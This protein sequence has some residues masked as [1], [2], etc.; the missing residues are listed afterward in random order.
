MK[1]TAKIGC[2]LAIMTMIIVGCSTEKNTWINRNYHSLTAHYN[3]YYNA[4]ELIDQGM[5]SYRDGRV[6]NYYEILPIDPVPDTAEVAALYPALDTAI[7]K[8]KKVIKNHSM[9]S[10]DRPARKKSEHNRWIDENWTTIGIASY[11]RRDYEGAMKSFKFVRKFYSND[12]SLY[13]GELWMAKT[14]IATGRLTEAK[15][16]L[17]NLDKAI[18]NEESAEE[19]GS[20]N[21]RS[22]IPG[23]K[24]KDDDDETAKVPKDIRFDLEKT[25]AQLALE[26]GDRVKA[27][28]YLEAS[29]EHA[30]FKDNVARVHFILGQLYSEEGDR[31]K[32]TEHFT[33][34]IK[35]RA[36]Y[37]MVFNARLKRAF[38]GTGEKVKKDLHKMMKDPKNSEFKD[39]I[40]YALAEIEFNE[41]NDQAAVDNLH[42]STFYS[43]SNTRQKGMSYERLGDY[44]FGRREYVQ[45]QK[46]YD[47]CA[48]VIK[49]TYPNA[50]G[51]RGKAQSLAKLVV[52]VET[53]NREDSLQ[54]IAMMDESSREK[55]VKDEIKRIKKAEEER[56][57]REAER[58]RE[59]QENQNL[60]VDVGNGS[61][62]YWNNPKVVREG[63]EEFRRLWG[64]RENE[65]NWRR[66]NKLDVNITLDSNDVVD[67]E[68]PV[69][70]EDTLTVEHLMSFVP[71]TD[72]MM[73]ASNTRLMKA[74]FDAGRIY[75]D[76]LKEPALA[77]KQFEKALDKG[78]M[79]DPHDLLSAYQLYHMTKERDAAKAEGYKQYILVNYPNSDFANYL[80]DPDYFIKK[81]E[82]D[83][84]AIQ[85]Y[86][87][88]LERYERALY[89]PVLTKANKVI[90]EEPDNIYRSKYM[91]L[92][93]MCLGKTESD[94]K[95]LLPVLEM[96]VEQYPGT[97]EA[98]RGQ[99][100]IDII[101]NGYSDNIVFEDNSG[102]FEFDERSKM[103]VIVFL[104]EGVSSQSGISRVS[105]FNNEYFNLEGL[106]LDTKLFGKDQ[107]SVIMIKEF[108]DEIKAS[109]Y[110]TAFKNTQKH[111]LSLNEAKI[112]M[113]SKENMATL[114]KRMSLQEYEDF[115]NEYY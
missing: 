13:V 53:A 25:K 109:T 73:E 19:K 2:L 4:N 91:L 96:L 110:I 44:R 105:S 76:Q 113:I 1:T 83:A 42:K 106:T 12:P 90:D 17:D 14:N 114:F 41:G 16:N 45:A 5:E 85:E 6:E 15:F 112:F 9:P 77:K 99:E 95:K 84:L 59:L 18:A 34:V 40:Y 33:K 104:P 3:G 98:D 30:R 10:N 28:E 61:K 37:E 87:K 92:K 60:S 22:K 86:V 89:Y 67:G 43:T 11:Y 26:R 68:E 29:L 80:R 51:I 8:C 108:E 115:Y 35:G 74:L 94:K 111:L 49:D 57:R 93:A 52:A 79:S 46:Y 48:R 58:L 24:K 69:K 81:K 78:I 62:W 102:I 56:K 70:A 72:S 38:L 107:E 47:S 82:R 97:E 55:F 20:K 54:R 31:P 39:Q 65:D 32:A 103:R 64:Q 88:V 71:L 36:K 63:T 21:K 7:V 100:M 66:S 23:R 75:N 101:N 27:I 50:D